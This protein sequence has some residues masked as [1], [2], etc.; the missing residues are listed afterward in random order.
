MGRSVQCR[1]RNRD[2]GEASML[3]IGGREYGQKVSSNKGMSSCHILV[4]LGKISIFVIKKFFILKIQTQ[5]L[6]RRN[7]NW[8]M[9]VKRHYLGHAASYYAL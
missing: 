2:Q 6:R 4:N 8:F 5:S 7:W 9:I 3:K 1:K